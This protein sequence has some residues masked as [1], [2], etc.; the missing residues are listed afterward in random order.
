MYHKECYSSVRI[1]S[2]DVAH[3]FEEDE[4]GL[5]CFRLEHGEMMPYT[6]KT[7][8]S[9]DVCYMTA[10]NPNLPFEIYTK[11]AKAIGTGYCGF[12]VSEKPTTEYDLKSF[13]RKMMGY[14][15]LL[16]ERIAEQVPSTL[17]FVKT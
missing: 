3:D 14:V 9:F 7:G 16:N 2:N 4:S 13:K 6:K 8:H 11:V 1:P 5:V 10:P 17:T 12:R 15:S